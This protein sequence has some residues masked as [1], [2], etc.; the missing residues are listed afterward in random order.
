MALPGPRIV[1]G[2]ALGRVE[3]GPGGHPKVKGRAFP[4]NLTLRAFAPVNCH[5]LLEATPGF[6]DRI[7]LLTFI[8][9]A[10]GREYEC[11]GC[12]TLGKGLDISGLPL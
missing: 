2:P 10:Y 4:C 7:N 3:E 8:A 9:P 6:W 11:P 5:L 12:V 1:G